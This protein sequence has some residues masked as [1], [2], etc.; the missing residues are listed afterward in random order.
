MNFIKSYIV[1]EQCAIKIPTATG[2]V[3]IR[4]CREDGPPKRP[5]GKPHDG[6]CEEGSAQ[7]GAFLTRRGVE[8]LK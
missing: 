6:F 2:R 1:R 8:L 4:I 3:N 5:A 7:W